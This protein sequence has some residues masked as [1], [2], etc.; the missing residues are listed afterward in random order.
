[1]I[2]N[3]A[4]TAAS[5]PAGTFALTAGQSY[6]IEVEYV[7]GGSSRD[8]LAVDWATTGVKTR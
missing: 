3:F 1:M 8:F 2:D 6:S 5:T 7:S 4:S